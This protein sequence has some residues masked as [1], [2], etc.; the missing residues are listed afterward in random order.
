MPA[1]HGYL[2][3]A[4]INPDRICIQFE[5]P[6]EQFHIL[7]FWGQLEALGSAMSWDNDPDHKALPVSA[8]WR[9][10]Y[11][12]AR[13]NF[14]GDGCMGCCPDEINISYQTYRQTQVNYQQFLSMMD[15]GDTAASFNAPS[16][17]NGDDSAARQ[18]ALCRT[19]NRLINSSFND[20]AMAM[21]AGNDVLNAINNGT[22]T[23]NPLNGIV[24]NFV[25]GLL[26]DHLQDLIEDCDAIRAVSCCF[27]DA[28][29]GQDT[30][31]ENLQA[32]LGGC[33]FG[34]GTHEA[35][36]AAMVNNLIQYEDNARCFIA[37]MENDH[38]AAQ[39]GTATSQDCACECCSDDIE[40]IDIDETGC[41][42]I[43]MG[44][45][46]F[47]I[48]QNTAN[49]QFGEPED[50]YHASAADSLGRCIIFSTVEGF[51]PNGDDGNGTITDCCDVEH[52]APGGFGFVAI[53]RT[54]WTHKAADR[55]AINSVYKVELVEPAP[56]CE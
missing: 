25:H 55:P 52:A 14:Y 10:V 53:K 9:D 17:F 12:V 24:G 22:I 48:V 47:R 28:L 7:A 36:I 8:V 4:V 29:T 2:L 20:A 23:G 49:Q 39:N 46:V 56:G 35:E 27:R 31:I 16:T 3:P 11:K 51:P 41:T 40:L 32:A 44:D 19:I 50:Y 21:G 33:G 45:C 30:T 43:P 26:A 18:Y 15:D 13:D 5:I 38:E 6:N 37:A 34:F 54:L 1:K 42:I